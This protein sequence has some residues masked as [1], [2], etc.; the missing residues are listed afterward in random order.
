MCSVHSHFQR[1]KSCFCSDNCAML[2]TGMQS[3]KGLFAHYVAF[4]RDNTTTQWNGYFTCPLKGCLN[5]YPSKPKLLEHIQV[6]ERL[7]AGEYWCPVHHTL[8][9]FLPTSKTSWRFSWSPKGV[10]FCKQIRKL[11]SARSKSRSISESTS[12]GESI[13]GIYDNDGSPS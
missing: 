5:S 11:C 4:H 1:L 13:Y 3:P 10:P 8:E 2:S 7:S 12:V 9:Q 6:C